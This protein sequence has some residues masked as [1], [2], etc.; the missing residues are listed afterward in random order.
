LS[1]ILQ[2]NYEQRDVSDE[3]KQVQK[4]PNQINKYMNYTCFKFATYFRLGDCCILL[5]HTVIVDAWSSYSPVK[6]QLTK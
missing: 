1:K 3:D 4:V 5:P 6:S 2:F